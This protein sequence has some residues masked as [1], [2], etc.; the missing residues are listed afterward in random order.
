MDNNSNAIS[1]TN[2]TAYVVQPPIDAIEEFKVQTSN[3]NAEFGRGGGAVLNASI[4]SGANQVHGDVWEFLRNDKLDA[5]DFFENANGLSKGRFRRNQ[6][7]FTV[8][9]PL[10]I[11]KLYNGRNKTFWFVDY[12]GTQVRQGSPLIS[13]VPTMA[14]SNSGYTNFADLNCRPERYGE[15]RIRPNLSRGYDL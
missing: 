3:Y 8:G 10:Y 12:E 14:E 2:G 11:P 9:G 7:G 13:T 1:M 6:F 15:G 5:A 4:K